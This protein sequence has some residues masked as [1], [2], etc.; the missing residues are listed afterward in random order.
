MPL[1]CQ[2]WT[3]LVVCGVAL[4]LASGCGSLP[5]GPL[6]PRLSG[7]WIQSGVDTY[8]KFV[9]QQRGSSV[10]GT[11][12][13]YGINSS[14]V[15]IVHGTA[16]LPNVVLS[17]VEDTTHQTFYGTLSEDQ[18]SLTGS[19]AGGASTVSFHRAQ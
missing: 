14:T 12:G 3:A 5:S 2:R 11:Y 17:W 16:N 10:V 6:D 19:Y 4:V 8:D 1:Q 9:L 18:R 15:Y 13:L 7:S